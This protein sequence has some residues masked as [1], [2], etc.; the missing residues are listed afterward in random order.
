[1]RA[2]CIIKINSFRLFCKHLRD[3]RRFR[4]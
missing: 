4:D 3:I 2:S 1:L